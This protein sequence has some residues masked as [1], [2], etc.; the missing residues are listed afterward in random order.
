MKYILA[1]FWEDLVDNAQENSMSMR[2]MGAGHFASPM[3]Q[4]VPRNHLYLI[5]NLPLLCKLYEALE[6]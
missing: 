6:C 2:A 1:D 3:L 4:D 5:Q